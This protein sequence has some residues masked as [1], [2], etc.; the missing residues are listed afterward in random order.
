MPG[1]RHRWRRRRDHLLDRRRGGRLALR[2]SIPETGDLTPVTALDFEAPVDADGDNVYEVT[3]RAS[4]G[5]LSDERQMSITVNDVDDDVE[6]VSYGGRG[7]GVGHAAGEQQLH[8]RRRRRQHVLLLRRDA[9]RS[10]AGPMRRCFSDRPDHRRARLR[11]PVHARISRLPADADGDNVY[12]VVVAATR[13]TTSDTQAFAI[14]VA[15]RNEGLWITSNGGGDASLVDERGQPRTSPPSS[16]IDPDGDVPD[17]FDRRRR[18]RRPVRDRSGDRG[19]DLHRRSG[20]RGAGRRR[21]RTMSTRSRSRASDGEFTDTQTIRI[22]IGNV[23]ERPVI[24]SGG[25]G[26]SAAV[27]VN[28]NGLA[29]TTVAASDADGTCADLCRSPAAPTR[30]ASRSILERRPRASS[31]AP[32][33]EAPGDAGGDNVYDVVVSVDRRRSSP[34]ARRSR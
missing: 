9:S 4:D 22:K 19:P 28:E 5:Q 15:N 12:D 8:R 26:A 16:P 7:P 20:F 33:F 10:R 2:R 17:L 24:T 34:T 29:V 21:R 27:T 13:L 30:R 11:L 25:G 32:N 23:N 14:T 6:I 1:D 31:Q 18:R 3:V